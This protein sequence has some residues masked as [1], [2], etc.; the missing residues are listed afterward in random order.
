MTSEGSQSDTR[1]RDPLEPGA[2]G[3]Y[4]IVE[5]IGAGGMGE[6]Y[7]AIDMRLGRRV[8]LKFLPPD[9]LRDRERAQRFRHE[10]RAASALNHPNILTV[11]EFGELGDAPYIATEYVEGETLRQ[12]L[13]RGRMPLQDVVSVATQIVSALAA[14]HA[15]GVIHRDVKPV[16][17][18]I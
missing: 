12:R 9:R 16:N 11:Y 15:A 3:P 5:R 4:R 8:A 10:A 13:Q 17:V 1:V 6:V 14:A 2:V 18:M 7:L